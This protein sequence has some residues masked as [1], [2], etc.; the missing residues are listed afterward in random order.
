MKVSF[1]LGRRVTADDMPDCYKR[2]SAW[3][4]ALKD[5]SLKFARRCNVLPLDN[6]DE[7]CIMSFMDTQYS[8]GHSFF[9]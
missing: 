1:A 9:E 7:F 2:S 6:I 5:A 8:T 4:W 3:Y